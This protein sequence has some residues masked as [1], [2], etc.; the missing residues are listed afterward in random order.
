LVF[1]AE[2]IY[3]ARFADIVGRT[4]L[5]ESTKRKYSFF[6]FQSKRV[7]LFSVKYGKIIE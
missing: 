5:S 6:L 3:F 2:G 4:A 1:Y 7:L